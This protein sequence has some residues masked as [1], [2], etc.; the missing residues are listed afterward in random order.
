MISSGITVRSPRASGLRSFGG[1]WG[2]EFSTSIDGL[3]FVKR[4]SLLDAI[5]PFV[6][7][8]SGRVCEWRERERSRGEIATSA[9]CT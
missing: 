9:I 2:T 1:N 3:C 7:G 6:F 5:C 8:L 4:L